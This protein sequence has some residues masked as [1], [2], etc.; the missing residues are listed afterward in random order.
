MG[1]WVIKVNINKIYGCS[2][3]VIWQYKMDTGNVYF[4]TTNNL[5]LR[6][7]FISVCFS[8]LL[9]KVRAI[10]LTV[11]HTKAVKLQFSLWDPIIIKQKSLTNQKCHLQF[12]RLLKE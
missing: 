8:L 2:N 5:N 9:F 6:T 4:N 7:I 12:N 1:H 11:H 3:E 10:Q